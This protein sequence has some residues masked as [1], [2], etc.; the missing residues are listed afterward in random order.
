MRTQDE[1]KHSGMLG[2]NFFHLLM[3]LIILLRRALWLTFCI[4]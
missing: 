2:K 4:I 1:R 3:R